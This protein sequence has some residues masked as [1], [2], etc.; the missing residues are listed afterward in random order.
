MLNLVLVPWIVWFCSLLPPTLPRSH[1]K[2]DKGR[3]VMHHPVDWSSDT[4][5]LIGDNMVEFKAVD[6]YLHQ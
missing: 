6:V 1:M 3:L 2:L 5:A 4:L